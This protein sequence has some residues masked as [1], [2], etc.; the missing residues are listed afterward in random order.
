MD[1]ETWDVTQTSEQAWTDFG[2]ALGRILA[3]LEDDDHVII[4]VTDLAEVEGKTTPYAQFWLTADDEIH[5]E[6]S[7]RRVLREP[8][9]LVRGGVVALRDAARNLGRWHLD[10]CTLVVTLEPCLMCAGAALLSHVRRVVFG[11]WDPKAGAAGS[12]WDVMR[13]RRA[14]ARIEV[15]GGVRAEESA[16]L[17]Q[18]FF[19]VHRLE[20]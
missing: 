3:E 16:Q 2:D 5:A 18:H 7:S 15:V 10:E 12:Q 14:T 1:D 11:A 13:D 9:R 19:E 4:Q 6:L 17:L 8:Y 20:D